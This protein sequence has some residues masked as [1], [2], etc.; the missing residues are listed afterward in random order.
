MRSTSPNSWVQ[1]NKSGGNQYISKKIVLVALSVAAF[2][3]IA[4]CTGL[5]IVNSLNTDKGKLNI[6]QFVICFNF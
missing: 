3:V 4:T 1:T 2:I 5:V 6:C